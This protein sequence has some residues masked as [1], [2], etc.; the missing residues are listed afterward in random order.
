[1]SLP[2]GANLNLDAI[3][4]ASTDFKDSLKSKLGGAG[5]FTSA[6]DLKSLADSKMSSVTAQVQGLLPTLPTVP[7]LS[8]QTEL[9]SLAG[10]DLSNPLGVL[11]YQ[12]KLNSI[13]ENFGSALSSGGFNLDDLVAQAAPALS[14]ATGALSGALDPSASASSLI[15]DAISEASSVASSLG[16]IVSGGASFDVCKDCPNFELEAG[17]TEAIQKAQNSVLAQAEGAIEKIAEIETNVDFN[18][19]ISTLT[20]KAS[21]ILARPEVQAK[22][23]SDIASAQEQISADIQGGITD[24]TEAAQPII[25]EVTPVLNELSGM[26]LSTKIPQNLKPP[27]G[28]FPK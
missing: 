18:A 15:N 4:S 28:L 3:T 17:A 10:I 24:V 16:S 25:K 21:N 26:S 1:M 19:E 6:S 7:P 2:C 20:T 23:S 9:T 27:K 13:T 12:S 22:I 5:T 11:D 14:T 8:F